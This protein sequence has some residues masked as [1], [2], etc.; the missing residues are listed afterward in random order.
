MPHEVKFPEMANCKVSVS[1]QDPVI[2]IS[3]FFGRL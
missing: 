2:R 3:K 1:P